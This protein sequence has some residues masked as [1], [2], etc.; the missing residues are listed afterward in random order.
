MAMNSHCQNVTT[1]QLASM[2]VVTTRMPACFV[3][4]S[5]SYLSI[6]IGRFSTYM[7]LWEWIDIFLITA[8]TYM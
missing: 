7:C 2:T 8:V 6:F 3:H 5:C 4:V 1:E